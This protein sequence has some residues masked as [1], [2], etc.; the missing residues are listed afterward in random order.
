MVEVVVRQRINKLLD[1]CS[2]ARMYTHLYIV[3]VSTSLNHKWSGIRSQ[4]DGLGKR[5]GGGGEGGGG[6]GV[7]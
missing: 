2:L 7:S 1:T 3:N 6:R 5:G 4:P